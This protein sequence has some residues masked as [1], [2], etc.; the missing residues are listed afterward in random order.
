M[1]VKNLLRS[2]MPHTANDASTYGTKAL[3]Q[4]VIGHST[5]VSNP[6]P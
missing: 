6:C 2:I 5:F 3:N 1:N 4:N